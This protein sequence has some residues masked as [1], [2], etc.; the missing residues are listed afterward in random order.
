M[1]QLQQFMSYFQ[2]EIRLNVFS[3]IDFHV[4]RDKERQLGQ[5][6]AEDGRP[7]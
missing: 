6:F 7:D 5:S 4:F 2:L 3:V 1:L